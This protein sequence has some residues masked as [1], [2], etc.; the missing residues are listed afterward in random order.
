MGADP[1]VTDHERRMITEMMGKG[2]YV[3]AV[4][5]ELAATADIML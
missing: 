2:T 1:G 5:A 4:D 3:A